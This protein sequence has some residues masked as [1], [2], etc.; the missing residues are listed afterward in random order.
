M[1]ETVQIWLDDLLETTGKVTLEEL[2]A[3]EIRAEIEEVEG[4][5]SNERLWELGYDGEEPLNPH[6]D[7][8]MIL[9]EYL[10]VLN[11]MLADKEVRSWINKKH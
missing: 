11:G 4:T 7:N 10:D 2:T 1:N 3:D 9:M 8:I 6:T 5:I